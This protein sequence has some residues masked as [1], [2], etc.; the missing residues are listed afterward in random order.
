MLATPESSL[1][2]V[3][4]STEA[5]A[6]LLARAVRDRLGTTWAIGETGTAGPTGSR[7]G[8]APGHACLAV[9]GPSEASRTLETAKPDRHENMSLFAANALGLFHEVISAVH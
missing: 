1:E 7:Y 5:Y 9:C 2:G 8:N 6:L 4:P 3:Q